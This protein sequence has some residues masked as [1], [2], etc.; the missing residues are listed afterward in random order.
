MNAALCLVV[1]ILGIALADTSQPISVT[2][3]DFSAWDT[4]LARYVT[5]GSLHT[6]G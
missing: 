6:H 1:M 2:N 5:Y 4:L 3:M